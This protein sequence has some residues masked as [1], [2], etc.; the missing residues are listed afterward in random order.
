MCQRCTRETP[1]M[2]CDACY[3][4]EKRFVAYVSNAL[5]NNVPLDSGTLA[6]GERSRQ[7]C[8][9]HDRRK[10]EEVRDVLVLA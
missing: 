4:R 3:E 9:K 2:L 8:E 7:W 10:A 5:A 6:N 1:Y